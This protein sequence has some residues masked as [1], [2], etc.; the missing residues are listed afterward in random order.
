MEEA[1]RMSE[2]QPGI[3]RLWRDQ[4]REERGMPIDDIRSKAE[5]F[6]QKSRRWNIFTGALFVVLIAVETWQVWIE[7]ELLERVGDLLT[8]A[9]LAY[10]LFWFRR[11]ATGRFDSARLGRTGSV[12][13]YREQLVLQRNLASH[14]WAY[15]ALF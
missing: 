6:D 10:M 14:P 5:R 11:Y 2:H 1:L 15:L 8:M 13:F 9:A 12:D 7:R 4:T 3:E